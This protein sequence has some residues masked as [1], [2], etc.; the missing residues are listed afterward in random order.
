[1]KRNHAPARYLEEFPGAG[2]TPE[3]VAF[4]RAMSE[5]LRAHHIRTPDC[6]DVLLVAHSLGYQK[7]HGGAGGRPETGR[8]GRG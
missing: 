4:G 2:L 6:R 7:T 3:Q 8:G 5:Y 1:M